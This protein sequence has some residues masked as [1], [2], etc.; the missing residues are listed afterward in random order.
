MTD[1]NKDKD[2]NGGGEGA[3]AGEGAGSGEG[4]HDETIK[5]LNEQ[6]ENLNKGIATSRDEAKTATEAAKAA[7]EAL[8]QFKKEA[9]EGKKPEVELSP[10][11]E[12]KFEAWA[13]A[14]GVV[15]QAELQAERQ[16]MAGDSAKNIQN[17][18]VS[19]FLE[20]HPEYDDDEQWQKVQEEFN[21]YKTPAD[22]AGYKKLLERVHK[23]LTGGDDKKERARAEARAEISRRDALKRGGGSQAAASGAADTEAAIDKMQERYPN[24]SRSQIE[25]RLGEIKSLYPDKD[26]K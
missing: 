26:K 11:D 18:A 6:I 14:N 4:S 13:K 8:E 10:E 3:G 1:V 19:D 9:D 5:K 25:S 20:K 24:L 7:T 21:L 16:K 23:N 17:Q 15:T 2:L 22:L 12:K